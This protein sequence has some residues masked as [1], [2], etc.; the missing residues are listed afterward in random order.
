MGKKN[1][2]KRKKNFIGI[3]GKKTEKKFKKIIGVF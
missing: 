2:N 1:E 3:I